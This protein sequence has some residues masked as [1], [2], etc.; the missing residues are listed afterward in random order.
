MPVKPYGKG[1]KRGLHVD[2]VP[3]SDEITQ[4]YVDEGCHGLVL[5]GPLADLDFLPDVPDLRFLSLM[6]GV[7][8][9]SAISRVPTLEFLS[10]A[11]DSR[12]T[13]TF[14][15]MEN[16]RILETPYQKKWMPGLADLREIHSL[17]VYFWPKEQPDL[18]IL[19][20]KPNLTDLRLQFKRTAHVSLAGLTAPQL[21]TFNLYDGRITDPDLF[22]NFPLLEDMTF[23]STKVHN[24]DFVKALPILKNLGIENGG[25][26][27]SV[28]PLANHPTLEQL[29]ISGRTTIT[30]G[31][32]HPLLNIPK[33]KGI[34]V[35][36]NA[37]HY[38]H[39]AAEVRKLPW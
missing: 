9:C 2:G 3:W 30:D 36:R 32:L 5:G 1:E 12:G 8:D 27:D 7:A 38:S 14:E 16:L 29:A 31:D 18:T 37:P 23:Y 34:A 10:L 17:M 21:K 35:E 11:T 4:R 39:R 25:D 19:G 33:A 6:R 20:D 13:F 15:G 24:L 26:I 22:A 28:T